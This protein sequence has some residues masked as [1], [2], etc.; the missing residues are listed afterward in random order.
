MI[1]YIMADEWYRD[2]LSQFGW[3]SAV[4]VFIYVLM[5]AAMAGRDFFEEEA[6]AF[7]ELAE[8]ELKMREKK[9]SKII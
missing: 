9:K 6:I 2:T 1:S 5:L 8:S 7:K 3:V 4:L